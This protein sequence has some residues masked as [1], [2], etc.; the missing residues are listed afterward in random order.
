[1]KHPAQYYRNIANGIARINQCIFAC[2]LAPV[3]TGTIY[4]KRWSND[5]KMT[6]TLGLI[7]TIN[8]N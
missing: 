6:N 7:N 2:R 3:E 1:M 5:Y 4:S 8:G